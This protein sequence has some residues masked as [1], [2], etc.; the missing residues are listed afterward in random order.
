MSNYGL[1]FQGLP[2]HFWWH[3]VGWTRLWFTLQSFTIP[4]FLTLALPASCYQWHAFYFWVE[5]YASLCMFSYLYI[6]RVW[7]APIKHDISQSLFPSLSP[8]FVLLT[9]WE[10]LLTYL[11]VLHSLCRNWIRSLVRQRSMSTWWRCWPQ[12]ITRLRNFG[13]KLN[14][15][16]ARVEDTTSCVM[17]SNL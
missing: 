4:K 10:S 6:P 9:V 8:A 14:S 11:C 16:S 17:T 12:R 15:K 3:R 7:W 5:C 2:Y 13:K 1:A